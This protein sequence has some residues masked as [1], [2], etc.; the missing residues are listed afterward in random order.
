MQC[1]RCR[2]LL[3]LCAVHQQPA[4]LLKA[5]RPSRFGDVVPRLDRLSGCGSCPLGLQLVRVWMAENCW[6]PSCYKRGFL[7]QGSDRSPLARVVTNEMLEAGK[8]VGYAGVLMRQ[9]YTPCFGKVQEEQPV[10][11][12]HQSQSVVEEDQTTRRE[13]RRTSLIQSRW[14]YSSSHVKPTLWYKAFYSSKVVPYFVGWL[15]KQ[16]E[17]AIRASLFKV[18]DRACRCA[19]QVTLCQITS[20]PP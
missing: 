19:H 8:V 11:C 9:H 13:Y 7:A 16:A 3:L 14:V 20:C 15:I 4:V 2:S 18:V 12:L 10:P 5:L 1:P 6:V 17:S